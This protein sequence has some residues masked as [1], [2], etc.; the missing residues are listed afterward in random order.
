MRRFSDPQSKHSQ[1]PAK[2]TEYIVSREVDAGAMSQTF[3]SVPSA[4]I[5]VRRPIPAPD[6]VPG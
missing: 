2:S 4:V 6:K 3:H 5:S 1:P